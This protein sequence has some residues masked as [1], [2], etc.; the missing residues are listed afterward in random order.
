[1]ETW[2]KLPGISCAYGETSFVFLPINEHVCPPFS[3]LLCVAGG[4][5]APS[6]TNTLPCFFLTACFDPSNYTP[7][8]AFD[9]SPWAH[10][11]T[12]SPLYLLYGLP[13]LDSLEG[14]DETCRHKSGMW[15]KE[16]RP[17]GCAAQGTHTALSKGTSPLLY[18]AV[19]LLTTYLQPQTK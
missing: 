4:G 8:H 15:H 12:V 10:L 3:V 9:N 7:P 18:T 11:H 6:R 2:R 17:V 14:Q 16:S 1:M 13:V 5:P 19:Q